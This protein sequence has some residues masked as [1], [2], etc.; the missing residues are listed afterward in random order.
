MAEMTVLHF[1]DVTNP[2]A[3][4]SGR[5]DADA[6]ARL[7]E[8]FQ[9]I[10]CADCHR[11]AHQHPHRRRCRW[12]TRRSPNDPRGQRLHQSTCVQVGFDRMPSGTGVD[13]P[14][15]ADLKRHDMGPR[16]AETFERGER[17]SRT[18]DFITARLW[19]IAD[20]APY[21]HDGRATTLDRGDRVP[22]R[23]GAVRARQLHRDALKRPERSDRLPAHPAGA[24]RPDQLS[25]CSW[26]EKYPGDRRRVSS[27]SAV[28]FVHGTP[29]SHLGTRR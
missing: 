12:P 11:P 25:R 26:S 20:T 10:G 4:C 15:F 7:P 16:L 28:A 21:L 1:F 14:L 3:A 2:R 19:G 17:R 23:R 9:N 8:L 18:S 29:V 24:G 13:V 27:P 6:A 5:I 22:R